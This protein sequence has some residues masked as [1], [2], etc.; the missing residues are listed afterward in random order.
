MTALRQQFLALLQSRGISRH[1]QT[2]YVR[3][4]RQLAEFSNLSPDQL[5]DEQIQHYLRHLREGK[6]L[7]EGTIMQ[8]LCGIKLVYTQILK[9]RWTPISQTSSQPKPPRTSHFPT[10]LRQRF[11]ED[12]QL[13]GLSART[14][15]AYARTVRQLA[16]HVKKSPADITEEELRQYFPHVNM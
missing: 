2:M 9:R 10:A 12:L 11:I 15:Q 8:L 13:Q 5:S 7:A 3:A 1:T 4:V 16:D 6:R 14:Q